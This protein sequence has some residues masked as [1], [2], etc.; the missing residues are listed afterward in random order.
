MMHYL[1]MVYTLFQPF[2][3]YKFDLNKS[4]SSSFIKEG[5][6]TLRID[7]EYLFREDYGSVY[8]A[9][10]DVNLKIKILG[11]KK[12]TNAVELPLDFFNKTF[13]EMNLEMGEISYPDYKF[14]V[15]RERENCYELLIEDMY[16]KDME[17]PKMILEVCPCRKD[18]GITKMD[19]HGRYKGKANFRTGFDL[20]S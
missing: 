16:M 10:I 12:E 3:V 15:V 18:L 17:D 5:T 9:I 20:K 4:R 7:K 8:P 1:L 6:V 19:F 11:R 14:Q 2:E 13:L